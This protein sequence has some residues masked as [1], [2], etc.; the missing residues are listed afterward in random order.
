[1]FLYT[2]IEADSLK[3][4]KIWCCCV[5]NQVFLNKESFQEFFEQN[6]EATW[7]FHNGIGFDVPVLEKLWN[8]KFNREK[9]VDTLVL[10]RLSN[11]DRP[12]GHSLKSYG[13]Q[14]GLHKGEFNNWSSLSQEMIDYC[15]RDVEV[16]KRTHEYLVRKLEGFSDKSINLEHSVAWI[17]A[18]QI[19]NGWL[20]D[21]RRCFILLSILR[22]RLIKVEEIVHEKFVPYAHFVSNV[23]PRV[24]KDGSLSRVG[25][26]FLDNWQD[27]VG[28]FSRIEWKEFN[29]GSRQ[30]VAKYLQRF[31]W[32]PKEFT[33]LGQA[34]VD[35][36]ILENVDI[37]EAN[38]IAEY[39]M[40]QKRIA[41]V[42]SWI[43]AMEEDG[44]VHGKVQTNGAVTGRM[45]HSN[46]NMAQVT[47]NGK[48]YGKE[49]RECWSVPKGYKL[50]GVDASGLE[51]R[52]L[53]HYMKD[54][55][56]T[57]E[58][59]QGD[60]HTKN[61][62]AAGLET[63]PQAKTF[64]Y[65][66]LYGAGDAKIGSIVG[67]GA[68][69][70]R[71]LKEKFLDNVPSLKL[72]KEKVA[73]RASS[74]YLK[75]VDGRLL[76]VRSEHAALNTLLQSA[77]AIVMKKA[78]CILDEYATIWNID[79]KFVGNI[80]DEIQAE[81]LEK[82]SSNFGRLAVESIKA[83]GNYFNLNCPLDGEFNIGDN[84]SETH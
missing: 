74:G 63:R 32:E 60:I 49:C 10:S 55:E 33:E 75:G 31:G 13:I 7:V 1:M 50:V 42:Q 48:P 30:Q 71:E 23:T 21:E 79:Y 78:L 81:V 61:Q 41:M 28:E 9:V 5:N 4:T 47:A 62:H 25:L 51:L 18:K 27:V 82:H 2:D 70:G 22:E 37:P 35:E 69:A 12:E 52:M 68:N 43:D 44:R 14:L 65:A 39:M 64:I 26:K 8:V 66:F 72:L 67:K 76:F 29:L 54:P 20:L 53:A 3:A 45:T 19:E 34:K 6:K 24:N 57:K 84:W 11:P 40:L 80:H 38:L 17:I 16:T 77:G 46:P 36:T 15:L 58:L 56:Y 83:A 59:L 73:R